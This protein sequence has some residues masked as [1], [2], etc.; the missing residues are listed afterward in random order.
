MSS[1]PRRPAL[2]WALSLASGIALAGAGA[3]APF[4]LCLTGALLGLGAARAVR[5]ISVR[6]AA[7]AL[8]A[9]LGAWLF[10]SANAEAL[11]RIQGWIPEEGSARA[12]HLRGRLIDVPE[13]V[14]DG[15]RTLL[16]SARPE[17]A[18][19][20][21]P[22]RILLRVYASAPE[23]MARLDRL[24]PGDLLRVWCRVRR[25]SRAGDPDQ[26]DPRRTLLAR[27]LD[28]TGTVKNADL[29]T[30]IE[31][32][33]RSFRR[34]LGSLKTRI[35]VRLDRALGRQ[36]PARA[37]LGAMLLGDRGSLDP[38]DWRALRDSGLVH[39]ISVSGLHVGL[40]VAALLAVVGRAPIG[41][42]GL[43][44]ILASAAA[45]IAVL[46]GNQPPVLRSACCAG[47]MLLGR[48]LGRDG[49][50]LN[51]LAVVT[52]ALA[53]LRPHILW[54]PS[55]QL[56]VS[57]TAGLLAFSRRVAEALPLPRAVG[58]SL[59]VSVGAYLASVPWTLVHF[60]RA[61][62]ASL[63]S[64][65]AAWVLCAV[66]MASGCAAASA[67][68]VPVLGEWT[69]GIATWSA[70]AFLGFSS[71]MSRIPCASFRV[72]SPPVALCGAYF[73]LLLVVARPETGSPPGR[74]RARAASRLLRLSVCIAL[75]LLHIG[76]P[77]PVPSASSEAAVLDV[78]QGQAIV[79]RGPTG[80]FVLVDAGG[81]GGGRFDS[82]ERVV[83]PFLA[84]RGCGRL[85]AL[86][87]S[88]DHDDHAGGVEAILRDFEVGE[89][90]L[91]PWVW[92]NPRMARLAGIASAGGTALVLAER[93]LRASRAGM[94]I[95]V[96]HPGRREPFLSENDRSLVVRAAAGA[97]SILIP[98]DLEAP[99]EEALLSGA[100]PLES[101]ALVV[102]HHGAARGSGQPF[103]AAVRPRVALVS[104]QEG[105]R[106]GQPDPA[107]LAR[108]RSAGATILR[109]DRN[110]RILLHGSGS[111][112]RPDPAFTDIRSG[113]E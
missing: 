5:S 69:A 49:D 1:D 112:W 46:T 25:P 29:V 31:K 22:I 15:G 78:G 81:T 2:P 107:V 24:R 75:A 62:P 30:R 39:L 14:R 104:A 82:G 27:G 32:G 88:H 35:R 51:T 100:G 84:R 54:D 3:T 96:L 89:L 70:Q 113:P 36:T 45:A 41:A 17:G 56:T 10:Q 85:E 34:L 72:G 110:G 53:V 48:A 12:L 37:L 94:D 58:L 7:L 60:G 63:L 66:A 20:T 9:A 68:S 102:G 44:L 108:L 26:A 101:A 105:N 13:E 83:A 52:A 79:L 33:P 40:A 71:T 77:P 74:P 92:R 38:E 11:A 18:G 95:A 86:V 47:F 59:G 109:T 55:F 64:N 21:R 106:F 65:L 61:T 43:F 98:G 19:G 4:F 73:A 23:A 6:L 80:G 67:V 50:A 111:G 99:G 76:P 16:L 90:W 42:F 8:V 103:L 91:A 93:G 28:A 57:A 87:V 97:S